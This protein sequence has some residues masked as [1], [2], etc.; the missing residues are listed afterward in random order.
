MNLLEYELCEDRVLVIFKIYL[1]NFS[2]WHMEDAQQILN[3]WV[4]RNRNPNQLVPN[5]WDF[6]HI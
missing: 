2:S 1:G 5:S 4:L 6:Y 3:T